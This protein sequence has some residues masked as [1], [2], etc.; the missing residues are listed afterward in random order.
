M[1]GDAAGVPT[2]TDPASPMSERPVLELRH[3]S[4]RFAGVQALEDV[5]FAAEPGQIHCLAGE[6]GSGKSTL[7]K[8]ISGVHQP[9]AGEML[10]DGQPVRAI[11]PIAAVRSG[12]QVIYQDFSLFGNLT[13][14]EN[15]ALGTEISEK[16]RFVNWRR[17]R[18]TAGEA[19][20]RLRVDI[21]LDALV[22]TLPVARKQLVA[23]ARALMSDARLL[24]MD[25]PTTALTG[26]EVATLFQVIRELQSRELSILFVSHKMHEML[27][28]S[29]R[30][31][32]I[33]NGRNI[34]TWASGD[35]DEMATMRAMTGQD[36]H[37][38]R[39]PRRMTRSADAPRLKV[40]NLSLD[41]ELFDVSFA[42]KAGEIL[43]IAGLLGSGRTELALALF[44]MRPDYRG[45]IR[46]DGKDIRVRNISE[47][48]REGI[49]YVPEDRLSE[50]LF[51]QQSINR[52]ILA[53][54]YE[55]FAPHGLIDFAAAVRAAAS[56]CEQMRV[57]ARTGDQSV[58]ELSGGNQQKVVIC[59]WLMRATRVLVLNGPTA[60]VDVGSKAA[61][62]E[63]VRELVTSRD[64]AVLMIS[65]D[66]PEL[67][68]NCNRILI[69][70][71]GR[72]VDSLETEGLDE[73]DLGE[74][75]RAL[76]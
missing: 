14:A 39:A 33:R 64:L 17:V 65:D 24:I 19:I 31:T 29:D 56:V 28:I 9:D 52:N 26:Q 76:Q 38:S 8:I 13:V 51:L 43:G 2:L 23:I 60:G 22:E 68:R 20:A 5:S 15:V 59:R 30:I 44:G 75:M 66:L 7:I 74:R 72:I 69:M 32:V 4:K 62:Y 55:V 11:T 37:G 70:H 1:T 18:R 36:L 48:I 10:I 71:R 58:K 41:G 25:E 16:R 47:A 34:A 54:S 46:L 40:S 61:I 21:P 57:A 12:I 45:E 42:C 73:D 35:F 50:G 53:G 6:N 3:L 67:V 27:E 63:K 49:A